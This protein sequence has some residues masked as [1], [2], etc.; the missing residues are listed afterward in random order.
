M[1][2]LK[3]KKEIGRKEMEALVVKSANECL[4]RVC[5]NPKRVLL[6]PPDITRAHS[7]GAGW[8]TEILYHF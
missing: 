4:I 8:M 6:L 3:G 7:G 2:F 1:V 5:K